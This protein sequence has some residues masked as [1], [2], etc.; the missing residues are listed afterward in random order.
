MHCIKF[1]LDIIDGSKMEIEIADAFESP[2]HLCLGRGTMSFELSV[3]NLNPLYMASFIPPPTT[4]LVLKLSHLNLAPHWRKTALDVG[5]MINTF[6]KSVREIVADPLGADPL[7]EG[8]PDLKELLKIRVRE[9]VSVIYTLQNQVPPCVK[10]GSNDSRIMRSPDQFLELLDWMEGQDD[11]KS[12]LRSLIAHAGSKPSETFSTPFL[13][14]Q[15]S[16]PALALLKV[17]EKRRVLI[18]LIMAVAIH[19]FI[20]S[21]VLGDLFSDV[22]NVNAEMVAEEAYLLA[23]ELIC[24]RCFPIPKT[25]APNVEF[26]LP[27]ANI[28]A[29]NPDFHRWLN[30]ISFYDNAEHPTIRDLKLTT[31]DSDYE[32]MRYSVYNAKAPSKIPLPTMQEIASLGVPVNDF[33]CNLITAE[34]YHLIMIPP[35]MVSLVERYTSSYQPSRPEGVIPIEIWQIIAKHYITDHYTAIQLAQ[36]SKAL[37]SL[38]MT[39][40]DK[41]KYLETSLYLWRRLLFSCWSEYSRK[42][43][44]VMP[45]KDDVRYP[46]GNFRA[47]MTTATQARKRGEVYACPHCGE[48][49]QVELKKRWYSLYGSEHNLNFCPCPEC[50]RF[51][52]SWGNC[53]YHRVYIK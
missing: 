49:H 27:N 28:L 6:K 42:R 17:G 25:C 16:S 37:E 24:T 44:H 38:I 8:G 11:D 52:G 34:F 13:P 4:L 31:A 33:L 21:G 19:Y 12:S 20:R 36:C 35:R 41:G 26:N 1:L 51:T 32:T 47:L 29:D 43:E 48:Y 40:S 39:Q 30:A 2:K 23:L 14:V 46:I 15:F 45:K 50:K 7:A 10:A 5:F 9:N 53:A 3:S 22:D 18:E